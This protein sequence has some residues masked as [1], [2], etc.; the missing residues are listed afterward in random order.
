[1]VCDCADGQKLNTRL[2]GQ[3][4]NPKGKFS[5]GAALSGACDNPVGGGNFTTDDLYILPRVV[6]A[7]SGEDV[8]RHN[9]EKLKF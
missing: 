3:Y 7:G 1:M 2:H 9:A 5:V 4:E 8:V 6:A